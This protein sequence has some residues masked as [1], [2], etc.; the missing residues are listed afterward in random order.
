MSSIFLRLA[1]SA[2]EVPVEVLIRP[3]VE[4]GIYT[5]VLDVGDGIP[6]H[7]RSFWRQDASAEELA[8]AFEAHLQRCRSAESVEI[9]RVAEALVAAAI[10]ADARLREVS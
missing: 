2:G 8:V 10:F 7:H 3:S 5:V 6:K 4:P 1:A 9:V